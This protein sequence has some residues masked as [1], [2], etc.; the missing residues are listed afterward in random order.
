MAVERTENSDFYGMLVD[1][2]LAEIDVPASAD[3]IQRLQ[4]AL[5]AIASRR[6]K[7]LDPIVAEIASVTWQRQTV[8]YDQLKLLYAKTEPGAADKPGAKDIL[9]KRLASLTARIEQNKAELAELDAQ[10][11]RLVAQQSTV[12]GLL[13]KN[14]AVFR[15]INHGAGDPGGGKLRTIALLQIVR[16]NQPNAMGFVAQDW[17]ILC[18]GLGMLSTPPRE[19]NTE[20][21]VLPALFG[22]VTLVFLMA[23]CSFSL[24]SAGRASI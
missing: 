2:Q 14:V 8:Q 16:V 20:G 12:E 19:S 15:D 22:T 24:G 17:T 4:S 11:N 7:V 10:S 9:D 6:A 3:P 1:L 13:R 5:T 18:Q 23:I 21:G